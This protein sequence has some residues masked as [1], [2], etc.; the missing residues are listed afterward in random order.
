[1][2]NQRK[3][4]DDDGR[5]IVNMNVEG[6][7]WYRPKRLENAINGLSTLSRRQTRYVIFGALRAGLAIAGV[8]SATIVLFVLFCL[9]VWFR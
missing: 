9:H 4:A 3:Y 2:K 6:M 7:P 5:T 1:M 8:M